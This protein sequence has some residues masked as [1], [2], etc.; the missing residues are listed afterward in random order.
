[1]VGDQCQVTHGGCVQSNGVARSAGYSGRRG[2]ACNI[3]LPDVRA[4]LDTASLAGTRS[5]R[6][7]PDQATSAIG[8][9]TGPQVNQSAEMLRCG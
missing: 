8:Q 2:T 7:Q 5:R 6:S 4:S 1:M 3:V 9:P